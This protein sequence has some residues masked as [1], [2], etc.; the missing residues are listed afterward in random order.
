MEIDIS[1]DVQPESSED[2]VQE[3]AEPPECD[4]PIVEKPNRHASKQL[5]KHALRQQAKRRRKNSTIVPRIIVKPLP[6]QPVEDPVPNNSL[7]TPT[8][9][10]V[11]ASIPGFSIKTRKRSSKKLSAAAQL[12]QTKEGCIDLE[13]PDSILVNTNL[14]ALLNKY[15]FATL[16]PLYQNKLVQLLPSVDRQCITN[17]TDSGI[18]LSTSGLN[19][20]FFSRACL[21]WQ[22][23]LGEGE[24][25]PENQQKLKSEADKERSRVDPWKLKHFE[26]IWGDR[27]FSDSNLAPVNRPPIKTTIKLR[28]TTTVS[29]KPKPT[30]LIK[31]LRTVGAMTRSCTSYRL[32]EMANNDEPVTKSPIPDLLPIKFAKKHEEKFNIVNISDTVMETNEETIIICN[33]TVEEKVSEKRPRSPSP[34]D[35]PVKRKTPSPIHNEEPEETTEHNI[36]TV[37]NHPEPME[38]IEFQAEETSE[39]KTESETEEPKDAPIV[40]LLETVEDQN[41]CLETISLPESLEPPEKLETFPSADTESEQTSSEEKQIEE[42]QD[43][44]QEPFEILP[45]TLILQQ[46]STFPPE[47][48]EKSMCSENCTDSNCME[49]SAEKLEASV[50]ESDLVMAQ[51]SEAGFEGVRTITDEDDANEDRFIDAENYVLESGQISVT[52]GQ[53]VSK[54]V[55]N[56]LFTTTAQTIGE[57]SHMYLFIGNFFA[58]AIIKFIFSIAKYVLKQLIHF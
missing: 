32:S 30:P 47:V 44:H 23:R 9:R 7:K 31:R 16:P 19:N 24:F 3:N 14:R 10:E 54:T 22:E 34:E 15:T 49:E 18:R 39:S 53:D 35:V 26:P 6:P 46:E 57:I 48:L 2:D 55:E 33:E 36:E 40:D 1:P 45:N 4:T 11:L 37:E 17:A 52:E 28:P 56:S 42:P 43:Y 27:S 21:E 58:L 29:N 13:T 25:T 5:I 12:E 51:L 20:E 38:T 50:E 8:M 41:S